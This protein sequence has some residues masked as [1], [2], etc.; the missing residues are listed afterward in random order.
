MLQRISI[1]LI[2]ISYVESQN[3]MIGCGYQNI[4][5]KNTTKLKEK[6]LIFLI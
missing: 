3:I 4:N 6:S 1:F 5:L 2:I